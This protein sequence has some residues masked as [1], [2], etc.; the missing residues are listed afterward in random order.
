MPGKET[1]SLISGKPRKRGARHS[2]PAPGMAGKCGQ[3]LSGALSLF[4]GITG[5]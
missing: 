4:S 3:Q 2:R 5:W 1:I